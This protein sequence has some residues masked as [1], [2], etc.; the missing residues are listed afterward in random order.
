MRQSDAWYRT[1]KDTARIVDGKWEVSQSELRKRFWINIS[2]AHRD[3]LNRLF[4]RV[5]G[6]NIDGVARAGRVFEDMV[7]CVFV[8]CRVRNIMWLV[9]CVLICDFVVARTDGLRHF[10]LFCVMVG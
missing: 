6:N 9:G 4:V 7:E 8:V 3:G 10:F 1:R 2:C 5:V